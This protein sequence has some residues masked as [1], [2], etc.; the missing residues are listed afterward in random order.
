VGRYLDSYL[1]MIIGVLLAQRKII[2]GFLTYPI[3]TAIFNI[4]STT[5]LHYLDD[6]L[7]DLDRV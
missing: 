6:H 2:P 3:N 5:A 4:K 1:A 7:I